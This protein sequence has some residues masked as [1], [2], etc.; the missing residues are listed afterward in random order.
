MSRLEAIE[1]GQTFRR[2]REARWRSKAQDDKKGA[3][4]KEESANISTNVFPRCRR[5]IRDHKRADA[6]K[7]S[8]DYKQ[9]ERLFCRRHDDDRG[10]IEAT[11]Y[12]AGCCFRHLPPKRI[13]R[14]T[15]M[16]L[17]GG[18]K[19]QRLGVLSPAAQ[20][21]PLALGLSGELR[22]VRI[23]HP[24]AHPLHAPAPP[25]PVV[26]KLYQ[27]INGLLEAWHALPPQDCARP[28]DRN[29][30]LS[31]G[32]GLDHQGVKHGFFGL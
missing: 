7:H 12:A 28:Y 23:G 13:S 15:L 19:L 32:F 18:N 20:G 24:Q 1:E 21:K 8:T 27:P 14:R 4:P 29:R 6:Y 3:A 25:L 10:T 16:P 30:A 5:A 9:K 11:L 2:E 17:D 22:P 31:S 26:L